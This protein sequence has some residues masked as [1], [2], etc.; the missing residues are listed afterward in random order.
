MNRGQARLE[1][2]GGGCEDGV[3]KDQ[4]THLED[5]SSLGTAAV[6]SGS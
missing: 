3:R 4:R 1:S 5:R 6:L 2:G